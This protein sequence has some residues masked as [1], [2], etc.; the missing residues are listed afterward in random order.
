MVQCQAFIKTSQAKFVSPSHVEC[1]AVSSP[2]IEACLVHGCSEFAFLVAVVVPCREN[3]L[4][5]LGLSNSIDHLEFKKVCQ[6]V[7]CR[8]RVLSEIRKLA[9]EAGLGK[10]MVSVAFGQVGSGWWLSTS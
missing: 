7:S 6:S 2:L 8:G 3:L 10:S 9:T 5:A 1:V 4:P